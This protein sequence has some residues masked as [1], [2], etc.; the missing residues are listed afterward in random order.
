MTSSLA[1]TER[2]VL[3]VGPRALALLALAYRARRAALLEG[4]TGIGKSELLR[5]LAL[6]LGI[7]IA[8]LDLSLLEPPDLVGLPQVRDGLTYY[9][10][11]A[12]L[13]RSGAGLLVLEELNRAERYVQQPALQL[14]SA[15]RVHDYVLPDEWVCFAAINPE[16]ADYHVTPLD[17]ALRARFMQLSLRADRGSWLLW[18]AKHGVHRGVIAVVQNHVRALDEVPPR[19][20]TY[21][22]ELMTATTK[23]ERDDPALLRDALGG[24][25]PAAWVDALLATQAGWGPELGLNVES[26][27]QSYL[28]DSAAK[29][30]LKGYRERGE[31]DRLDEIAKRLERVLAGPECG[32]L[33]SENR[34]HLESFEAVLADLPGDHRAKLQAALGTNVLAASLLPFPPTALWQGYQDGEPRRLLQR[35]GRDPLKHHRVE[36]AVTAL[37]T[38]LERQPASAE[39]KRNNALRASTGYL[40]T[41]IA[42][43]LAL[44]LARVLQR[45]D[46]T[47]QRP[48]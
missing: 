27:L 1:L 14:L 28:T 37:C 11:P 33:V 3:P 44:K 30:E 34:L 5:D 15:R 17:R 12:S 25:L 47:P 48:R 4:P 43:P 9:A 45:L 8:V 31:T 19:T 40:L 13:P 26:L 35:W 39:L 38:Y 6:Q 16:T 20:W 22:G 23:A 46:I 41:D 32:V 18:A 42:E 24:Y 36:L 29:A 10:T 7:Q 21:V 2:N